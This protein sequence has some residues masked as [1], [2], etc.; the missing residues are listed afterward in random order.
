SVVV[1]GSRAP[2][3]ARL[4][5]P[6]VGRAEVLTVLRLR[7]AGQVVENRLRGRV[8]GIADP[9]AAPPLGGCFAGGAE[10]RRNER[11]KPALAVVERDGAGASPTAPERP[12]PAA[13]SAV[14][15]FV[16]LGSG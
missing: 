9:I 1:A 4:A 14:Q 10:V 3:A 12:S 13:P 11:A 16:R 8:G 2:I 5:P 7:V 6:V 15:A